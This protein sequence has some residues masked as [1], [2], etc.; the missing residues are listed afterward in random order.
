M[1]KQE[2]PLFAAVSLKSE[3]DDSSS[4]LLCYSHYSDSKVFSLSA[5]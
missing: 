1:M 2:E 4:E 5:L 3:I